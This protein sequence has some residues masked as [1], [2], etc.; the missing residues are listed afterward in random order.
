MSCVYF[1]QRNYLSI[2]TNLAEDEPHRYHKQI[3]IAHL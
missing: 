2:A 3:Q 1:E